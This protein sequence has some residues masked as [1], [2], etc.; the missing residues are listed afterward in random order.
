MDVQQHGLCECN[1]ARLVEAVVAIGRA[2]CVAPPPSQCDLVQPKLGVQKQLVVRSNT[3]G[4][5]FVATSFRC[6]LSGEGGSNGESGGDGWSFVEASSTPC[7]IRRP[8]FCC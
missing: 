7:C 2:G 8:W 3:H 5:E 4:P 6:R 1:V